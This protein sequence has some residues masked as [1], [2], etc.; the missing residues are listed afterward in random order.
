MFGLYRTGPSFNPLL[1]TEFFRQNP[2]RLSLNAASIQNNL[3]DTYQAEERILG[4]YAMGTTN[5]GEVRVVSGVRYE[6]TSNDYR[7]SQRNTGPTGAF[8]GF[9]PVTSSTSFD[10]FFPS[11]VG[12][13]RIRPNLLVR[14]GWT[15]TISR[16]NYG[17]LVPK[18]TI[19]DQADTISEGNTGLQALESMNWDLSLEWYLKSAG[20]LSASVF[21]KEI[22]NFAFVQTSTIAAGEFAGFR[23]TRPE[24]GPSGKITGAEF[25]WT[26]T[27]R[28]LPKPFDGLGVQTNYTIVD[29]ESQVPG[30]GT[31]GFLPGQV[32]EVY[33]F[34]VFYE[35]AGF[36]ARVAYN[37]NGKY[38]ESIG[39]TAATD[40]WFDRMPTWDAS[41]SYRVRKG[42]V[43]Y[44]DGRNL[45]DTDKRRR[46]EGTRERPIEQEFAGW[47]IVAGVKFEL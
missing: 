3:A 4:A 14:A 44:L 43:L 24:N 45:T 1:G 8:L 26:Q 5:F 25:A 30:R 28:F 36:S 37:V 17:A 38:N 18:R 12:T 27:F 6:K 23:L 42:W 40:T 19:N 31:V 13:Y 41:V 32:D 34:Q 20:I 9:T 39:A 21:H 35:K 15:N 16:A 22:E 33:N 29:G 2:G 11:L 46:Y 47:S 7:A 10:N